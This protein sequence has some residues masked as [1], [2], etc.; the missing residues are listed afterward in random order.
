MEFNQGTRHKYIIPFLPADVTDSP[1]G[2]KRTAFTGR[3]YCRYCLMG[4]PVVASQKRTVLL[5]DVLAR[6]DPSGERESVCM[7]LVWPVHGCPICSPVS[8]FQQRIDLSSTAEKSLLPSRDHTTSKTDFRSPSNEPRMSV[9]LSTS[10]TRMSS[11]ALH[12]SFFPSGENDMD[13]I[14]ESTLMEWLTR[15]PSMV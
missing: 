5:K 11:S 4:L 15:P 13:Q 6:I 1:E 10:Y 9:P 8:E 2:E 14:S 3:S 7:M 12:A